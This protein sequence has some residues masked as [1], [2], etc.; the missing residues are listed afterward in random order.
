VKGAGCDAW[1]S[2]S[3]QSGTHLTGGASRKCESKYSLGIYNADIN[4]VS[5]TMCNGTS[6]S[7]SSTRD[8]TDRSANGSSNCA[9]FS[10]KRS[11]NFFG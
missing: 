11:K 9:L 5:Q 7:S 10:I 4:C 6:F 8:D 1:N 2:E 3:A